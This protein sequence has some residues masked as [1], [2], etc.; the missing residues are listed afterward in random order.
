MLRIRTFALA[1]LV[2]A[3]S[4]WSVPQ[5]AEA[6]PLLDWI[7]N[8]CR[9]PRANNCC[10]PTYNVNYATGNNPYNLQPN[11]CMTT[12]QQTCSRV[13]VNYVPY[14]A[15]RTCWKRVPVTQYRPVTKTDPC[16]GCTTTCMRP[17]TTYT[18][19]MQRVPYT[20]YRPCYRTETYRVPVTTIS[21]N[22]ATGTCAPCNT[23][24]NTCGPTVPTLP[25]QSPL[26]PSTTQFPGSPVT[27]TYYE[28]PSSVTVPNG[29]LST[30]SG[31]NTTTQPADI[32]PSLNGVNPQSSNRPIIDRLGSGATTGQQITHPQ[33]VPSVLS[34]ND[35][36]AYTT[37]NQRQWNYTPVRLASHSM[38]T[39]EQLAQPQKL[40]PIRI[41]G[42]F[43]PYQRSSSQQ[44]GWVKKN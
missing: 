35:K 5:D 7:R 2:T 16:S 41:Q 3:T 4:L 28:S 6:G 42:T 19:Q 23:G 25:N 33:T 44:T 8:R 17:C 37:P 31:I 38:P 36:T 14:T 1:I 10:P 15:Y 12:C 24:C 43:K 32:P 9:R 18:Y 21:N 30:G 27:G 26:T 39:K 29:T 11:Q 13:V 22:C 40:P 34:Y 20:T